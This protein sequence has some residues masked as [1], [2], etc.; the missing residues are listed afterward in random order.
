MSCDV[1][2]YKSVLEC[3]RECYCVLESV[4]KGVRVLV[5]GSRATS[6]LCGKLPMDMVMVGV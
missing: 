2:E 3:V 6:A 1:I 4:R 5:S